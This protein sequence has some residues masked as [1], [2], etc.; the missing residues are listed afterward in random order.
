MNNHDVISSYKLYDSSKG[1]TP[2]WMVVCES[3]M[4]VEIWCAYSGFCDEIMAIPPRYVTQDA[5]V[6]FG[7][8]QER[9]SQ[10]L[11]KGG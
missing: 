9:L 6:V 11:R 10:L 2:K 7:C 8:S 4:V 1:K 3:L 5:M